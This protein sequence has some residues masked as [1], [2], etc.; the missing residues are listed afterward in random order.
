M[1][2]S[3]PDGDWDSRDRPPP[4]AGGA[5]AIGNDTDNSFLVRVR[6]LKDTVDVD[7]I[8]VLADPS[9]ALPRQLFGAAETWLLEAGRAL[10]LQNSDGDCSAYLIETEGMTATLLAWSHTRF[11]QASVPTTTDGASSRMA[12]II[13]AGPTWLSLQHSTASYL[14]SQEFGSGVCQIV[15]AVESIDWSPV[16]DGSWEVG[17]IQTSPNGC[18]EISFVGGPDIVLC[19][20]EELPFAVGESIAVSSVTLEQGSRAADRMS[21]VGESVAIK[22]VR[23]SVLPFG[24]IT[25][26]ALPACQIQHDECG[27]S[28]RA[29]QIQFGESAFSGEGIGRSGDVMSTSPGVELHIIRVQQM[30]ARDLECSPAVDALDYLEYYT[31]ENISEQP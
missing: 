12:R 17:A 8:E 26:E 6:P 19:I 16:P 29:A 14:R 25:V 20:P 10:P 22:V 7:C 15:P 23:G 28:V 4:W 30:P 21:L 11:P 27:N 18:S 1:A 13:N 31:V 2:T 24:A 9:F 5:I 3:Q